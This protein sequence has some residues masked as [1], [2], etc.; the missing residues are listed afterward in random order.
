M[1]SPLPCFLC[2]LV[3]T[4][5]CTLCGCG[6]EE[7]L[8]FYPP[9]AK[10][11]PIISVTPLEFDHH[12]SNSSTYFRGYDIFYLLVDKDNTEFL[13]KCSSQIDALIGSRSPSQTMEAI[14]SLGFVQLVGLYSDSGTY[15][16]CNNVPLFPI[17]TVDVSK[18]ISFTINLNSI[19]VDEESTVSLNI[20]TSSYEDYP[21]IVRRNSFDDS[22]KE[23]R[24]FSDFTPDDK[25]NGGDTAF[26]G[27][28]VPQHVLLRGYIIGYGRTSGFSDVFSDPIRI[29]DTGSNDTW[30]AVALP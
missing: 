20:D 27:D 2:A 29:G 5:A 28:S 25:S 30:E 8:Y 16:P 21:S 11:T 6:I 1:H 15:R 4:L 23:Y 9:T 17:A 12:S 13:K 26:L 7:Y 14:K 10:T 18:S 3:V 22:L 19:N 24:R